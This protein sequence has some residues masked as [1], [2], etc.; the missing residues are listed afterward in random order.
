MTIDYLPGANAT[1]VAE[2]SAT[3]IA[4]RDSRLVVQCR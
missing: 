3:P 1:G 4:Y 2:T